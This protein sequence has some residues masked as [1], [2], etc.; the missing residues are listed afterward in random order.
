MEVKDILAKKLHT[1]E[2]ELE[3]A[4]CSISDVMRKE[5]EQ[6]F[7]KGI[8][9][10]YLLEDSEFYGH[11]F[12][13][14]EHVLIPRQET[15][16]L[17]DIIVK[18]NNEKISS[19]L[20]VGTG[21]GVILLS[22]LSQRIGDQGV[23]TDISPEAL[24]VARIN[25]HRLHLDEKCTLILSDRFSKVEGTFD[26]IVSN[27]PYIKVHAHRALV[28]ENVH[29]YEPH[30]ALYLNDDTYSEWF[31]TFFKDVLQKLNPGGVFYMEGHEL[32]LQGQAEELK[33]LGFT[34]VEVLKDLTGTE[35]FLKAYRTR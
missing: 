16:Y 34:R 20:D 15:E 14:N 7:L 26:L 32:E 24:E 8:P 19:V 1:R 12:F 6:S 35:R 11:H 25:R 22:L 30:L 4:S 18:D 21:S 13:V 33:K 17:V 10:Q 23:G 5:L 3:S 2:V 31:L 27:P 9:F 29:T 28:H